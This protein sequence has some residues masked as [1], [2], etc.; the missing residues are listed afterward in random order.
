MAPR[1][2][3]L[4]G[5][6]EHYGL[7]SFGTKDI[8]RIRRKIRLWHKKFKRQHIFGGLMVLIFV[9]MLSKFLLLNMFSEQLD[10]DPVIHLNAVEGEHSPKNLPVNF[11][12]SSYA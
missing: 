12:K 7:M 11:E 8:F 2:G 9:C 3:L 6:E 10:L 5:V 1:R 4:D